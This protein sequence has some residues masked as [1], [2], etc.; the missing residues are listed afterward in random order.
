VARTESQLNLPPL[1]VQRLE[2]EGEPRIQKVDLAE[3]PLEMA[4]CQIGAALKKTIA[5]TDSVLKDFGDPSQVKRVCD[6]DVP[7]VLARAWQRI[8]TRREFVAA[9]AEE[10][11]LFE[12]GRYMHERRRA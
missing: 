1:P 6:G 12:V 9:L 2:S 11:G 5:R 3:I 10:S 4:K 8:E 7:S